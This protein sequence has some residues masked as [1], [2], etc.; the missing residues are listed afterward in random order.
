MYDEQD[1]KKSVITT[2]QAKR[3]KNRM[4]GRRGLGTALLQESDDCG[5]DNPEVTHTLDIMIN[6]IAKLEQSQN[7]FN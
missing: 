4:N 1:R 5:E 2:A 6:K 3:P 7:K